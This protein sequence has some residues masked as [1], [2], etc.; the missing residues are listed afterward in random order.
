[1][2]KW[3][4]ALWE[5]FFPRLCATCEKRLSEG[6]EALCIQCN[7]RLPRTNLHLRKDHKIEKL[8]WGRLH[9]EQATSYFYYAKGSPYNRLI[10]HMKYSRQ[11]ELGAVLGRMMAQELRQSLFFDGIDLLIPVP[12]HPIRE[13]ER[14][15][16]QS[17]WIAK[18]VS[19]ITGI[20]YRTDLAHKISHTD[21]QA[22]QDLFRRSENTLRAFEW[23]ADEIP[24]HIHI[25]LIDD[26]LTTGSTLTSCLWPLRERRDLKISILTLCA[27]S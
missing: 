11:K 17:E 27:V 2:P 12:L 25:L 8:F 23:K 26:V 10:H 15:Y 14:G 1:M 18:G 16:N 5:L 3:I 4:E 19:E 6:E 20:P 13:R 24:N 21:P 7:I 9:L 22:Q